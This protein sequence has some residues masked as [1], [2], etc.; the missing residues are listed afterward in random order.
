MKNKTEKEKERHRKAVYRWRNKNR[1]KYNSRMR[2]YMREEIKKPE[3]KDR[4]KGY[5]KELRWRAKTMTSI[6]KGEI[7][8]NSIHLQESIIPKTK[9]RCYYCGKDKTPAYRVLLGND[10]L[11]RLSYF[12]CS[13]KC[14][15]KALKK[16]LN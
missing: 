7:Q 13:D 1:D 14:K 12:F 5:A 8:L 6:L 15:N 4:M 10:L 16:L 3:V 2:E 11:S 9:R